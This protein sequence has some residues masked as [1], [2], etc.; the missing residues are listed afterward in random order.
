MPSIMFYQTNRK[1]S[2]IH[3]KTIF[4]KNMYYGMLRVLKFENCLNL[5]K[6]CLQKLLYSNSIP[7]F[8]M[9]IGFLR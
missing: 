9:P 6:K 4:L 7:S 3:G 2:S 8:M 5:F 1:S